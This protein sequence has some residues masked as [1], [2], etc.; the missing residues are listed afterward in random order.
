MKTL[1]IKI[2]NELHRQIR[3]TCADRETTIQD[4]I[5]KIIERGSSETI[6]VSAP[7]A[8]AKPKD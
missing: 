8:D 1:V 2:P 5:S 6:V 3:L 7:K 4:Y